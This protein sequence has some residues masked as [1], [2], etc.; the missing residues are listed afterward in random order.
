MSTTIIFWLSLII[1]PLLGVGII[2]LIRFVKEFKR[3][4]K[5]KK[6]SISQENI[7]LC[8]TEW[9]LIADKKSTLSVTKRAQVIDIINNLIEEGRVKLKDLQ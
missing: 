5:A 3:L 2:Y 9:K 8:I 4:R 1:I 6:S 7:D